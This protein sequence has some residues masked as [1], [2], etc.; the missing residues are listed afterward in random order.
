M[1][2]QCCA[3]VQEVARCVLVTE[4]LLLFLFLGFVTSPVPLG[5]LGSA[6]VLD[7]PALPLLDP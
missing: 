6:A 2:S 5:V 3:P 1:C 4:L 7:R